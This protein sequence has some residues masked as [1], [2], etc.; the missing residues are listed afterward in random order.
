[1]PLLKLRTGSD[2]QKGIRHHFDTIWN[3]GSI[4]GCEWL[5]GHYVGSDKGTHTTGMIN[6]FTDPDQVQ[7]RMLSVLENAKEKISIQGITLHSFFKAGDLFN[8]L[9]T[10]LKNK[11]DVRVRVLLLD[12]TCRQAV[13]RSYREFALA[14]ENGD[15]GRSYEDYSE[16]MNLHRDMELYRESLA[17]IDRI[18]STVKPGMNFE[19]HL[20]DSAPACF[21]LIVDGHIFVEQYGFGKKVS[22]EE[23]KDG[24]VATLGGDMPL[25]E[26]CSKASPMY[27]CD[28][29]PSPYEVLEDHFEF[30]FEHLSQ[31][32]EPDNQPNRP[33][34]VGEPEE[35]IA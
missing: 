11:P 22:D 31:P 19:A 25:V 9:L 33:I 10:V 28:D 24:I 2:L 26:Y 20:Y 14:K 15:P 35:L 6:F 4:D 23:R 16:H 12:P 21:V 30:V 5:D 34:P 7:K 27:E 18:K 29:T 1:M 32:I 3:Y 17:S 13:Q 8:E